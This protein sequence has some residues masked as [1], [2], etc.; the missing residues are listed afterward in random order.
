MGN[1]QSGGNQTGSQYKTVAEAE[2]AYQNKYATYKAEMSA[3][4]TKAEVDIQKA[5]EKI[6]EQE[7]VIEDSVNELNECKSDHEFMM[8]ARR[9][10]QGDSN[11]RKLL[12]DNTDWTVYIVNDF[13]GYWKTHK[14]YKYLW[15]IAFTYKNTTNAICIYCGAGGRLGPGPSSSYHNY[16][17]INECL[18]NA[19]LYD[20][21]MTA[22]NMDEVII[23]P[24][25]AKKV[26]IEFWAA[27]KQKVSDTGENSTLPDIIHHELT[28]KRKDSCDQVTWMWNWLRNTVYNHKGTDADLQ[29]FES[30]GRIVKKINYT[31]ENN[32]ESAKHFSMKDTYKEREPL[33]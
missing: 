13:N 18:I 23:N 10:F 32:D 11:F 25:I 15:N 30:N 20:S 9:K 29:Q 7:K 8:I 4:L 24:F 31:S 5:N 26:S 3:K 28:K 27:Y 16:M 21:N 22:Y 2:Q 6:S 19:I 17:F 12:W 14:W 33:P 1:E